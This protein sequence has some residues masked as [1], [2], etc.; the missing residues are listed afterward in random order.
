MLQYVVCG[1]W[2]MYVTKFIEVLSDSCSCFLENAPLS[3][4]ILLASGAAATSLL[5]I[6]DNYSF[7][8]HLH[9]PFIVENKEV[10]VIMLIK[11]L[12]YLSD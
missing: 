2:Y 5:L 8:F 12:I 1:V 9:W 10:S 6:P 7:I 3:K 11:I 4:L